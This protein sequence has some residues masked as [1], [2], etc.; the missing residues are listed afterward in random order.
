V[1][2]SIA[3]ASVADIGRTETD[4]QSIGGDVP[5]G[6]LL[7][8]AVAARRQ[9]PTLS[10]GIAVRY[11]HGEL[12]LDQRT[13]V[14]VD[15]GIVVE[16][17]FRMDGRLGLSSF[18]W[19]PGSQSGDGASFSGA[20]DARLAGHDTLA[21]VRG[22]Y[23]LTDAPGRSREHFLAASGRLGVLETRVGVV[24]TNAYGHV[25]TRARLAL[26]VHYGKYLI[27]VAREDS[28]AGLAASY[29]FTLTSS[30]LRS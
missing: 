15:A 12:D 30:F 10:T 13:T 4:P 20:F 26:G 28:P 8:S 21:E 16:R 14:G 5:Y 7:I 6:T 2:V 3:R 25:S 27:A 9:T 23:A 19:R 11:I 17:L 24:R 29:Q 1:G 22:S 18:F